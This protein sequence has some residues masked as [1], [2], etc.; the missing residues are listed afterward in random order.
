MSDASSKPPTR[1]FLCQMGRCAAVA[2]SRRNCGDG[3]RPCGRRDADEPTMAESLRAIPESRALFSLS[4][5]ARLVSGVT[6]IAAAWYLLRARSSPASWT[7]APAASLLCLSGCLHG[8]VRSGRH[9]PGRR[10]DPRASRRRC[11]SRRTTPDGSWARSGSHW[12]G[13]RSL[14]VSGLNGQSRAHRAPWPSRRRSWALACCSSGGTP[15]PSYTAPSAFCSWSGC[16]PWGRRSSGAVRTRRS[17]GRGPRQP[18]SQSWAQHGPPLD[19]TGG[20]PFFGEA[21]PFARGSA[22]GCRARPS[23]GQPRT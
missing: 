11:W 6:L 4:A 14:P 18:P 2:Y 23:A 1:T 9:H 15:R 17:S 20:G 12:L 13:W 7:T 8:G 3:L 22:P 21:I 19:L 5:V 16:W 10:S